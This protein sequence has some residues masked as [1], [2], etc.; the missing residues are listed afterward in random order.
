MRLW[1]HVGARRPAHGPKLLVLKEYVRIV[2]VGR[3]REHGPALVIRRAQRQPVTK[4]G[5]THGRHLGEAG[6]VVQ[7][8]EGGRGRKRQGGARKWVPQDHLG[9]VPAGK[10]EPPRAGAATGPPAA[11]REEGAGQIREVYPV[12][13]R[14]AEAQVGG[15]GLRVGQDEPG[16]LGKGGELGPGESVPPNLHTSLNRIR[17]P[18]HSLLNMRR[19]ASSGSSLRFN[20]QEEECC[21]KSDGTRKIRCIKRCQKD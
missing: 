12:L 11:A 21:G 8:G 17:S 20:G 16:E 2:L 15:D 6:V 4:A 9:W 1:A 7:Q 13:V 3:A 14:A 19:I 10:E 5:Q 18:V